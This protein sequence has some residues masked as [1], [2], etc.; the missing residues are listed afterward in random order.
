MTPRTL[1]A[2]GAAPPRL[3]R[4]TWLHLGFGAGI[5]GTFH[6][7]GDETSKCHVF[8]DCEHESACDCPV[9]PHAEC[10]ASSWV[11]GDVMEVAYAGPDDDAS[12]RDGEIEIAWDGDGITWTYLTPVAFV[13]RCAACGPGYIGSYRDPDSAERVIACHQGRGHHPY[14]GVR[15]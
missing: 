7:A 10:W 11:G 8:R 14:V 5:I 13:V 12:V 4:V 9:F 1:D 6:C 2:V 15:S 3:H